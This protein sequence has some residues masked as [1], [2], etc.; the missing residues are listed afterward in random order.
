MDAKVLHR[1]TLG[2][3]VNQGV[4]AYVGRQGVETM[5]CRWVCVGIS[6]CF[7][8]GRASQPTELAFAS[9]V[10]TVPVEIN[11]G[12]TAPV[13][14]YTVGMGRT[15]S[16]ASVMDDR[17]GSMAKMGRKLPLTREITRRNE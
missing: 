17:I 9:L 6:R 10:N 3:T 8:D 11:L 14:R 13:T 2:P 5:P 7:L 12:L 16:N 15:G 1:R 4:A